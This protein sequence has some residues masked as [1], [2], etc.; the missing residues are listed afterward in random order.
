MI[1]DS[2]EYDMKSFELADQPCA[3]PV[4]RASVF[5]CQQSNVVNMVIHLNILNAAVVSH[6]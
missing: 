1:D 6:F 3:E 5:I 4:F 2:V